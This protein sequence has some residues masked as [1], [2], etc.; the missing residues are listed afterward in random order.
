MN[1]KNENKSILV[2]ARFF[3]VFAEKDLGVFSALYLYLP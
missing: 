2:T 1:A 3:I